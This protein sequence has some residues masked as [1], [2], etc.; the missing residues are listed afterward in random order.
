M[1][2]Y[3][4]PKGSKVSKDLFRLVGL[5][6]FLGVEMDIDT[7]G[8][9]AELQFS[10]SNVDS[11]LYTQLVYSSSHQSVIE[12]FDKPI[13]E[14]GDIVVCAVDDTKLASVKENYDNYYQINGFAVDGEAGS[15]TVN[16]ILIGISNASHTDFFEPFAGVKRAA[17][18]TK[19]IEA[20]ALKLDAENSD[21]WDDVIVKEA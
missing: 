11:G 15:E 21:D 6:A 18:D 4:V 2:I 1:N 10:L 5:S 17:F 3:H 20:I 8:L 7:Q 16:H 19:K 14:A 9:S 13:I 12:S